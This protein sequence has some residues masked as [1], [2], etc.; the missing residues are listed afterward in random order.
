M[1]KQLVNFIAFGLI[2]TTILFLIPHITKN[3]FIEKTTKRIELNTNEQIASFS[4]ELD[5]AFNLHRPLVTQW[6]L[7]LKK[8]FTLDLGYSLYNYP[9]RNW[10]I[11]KKPFLQTLNLFLISILCSWSCGTL[12]GAL[13]FRVNRIFINRLFV[14]TR[15]LSFL[16]GFIYAIPFI[17]LFKLNSEKSIFMIVLF[18]LILFPL[19]SQ[20]SNFLKTLN[21]ELQST[22]SYF[23]QLMG[24]NFHSYA[25]SYIPK[26]MLVQ[27]VQ[28]LRISPLIILNLIALDAFCLKNGISQ[29]VSIYVQ[30]YDFAVLQ[31]TI[32][33]IS[34]IGLVLSYLSKFLTALQPQQ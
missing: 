14:I 21:K 9:T 26:H 5:S 6:A 11:L 29:I 10:H 13:I 19:I 2:L 4:Q 17:L 34:L 20:A 23:I 31:S 1:L 25:F 27:F 12:L 15:F 7:Q 30:Q 3:D 18:S 28:L 8:I 33:L 16:P 22:S 24:L 32:I